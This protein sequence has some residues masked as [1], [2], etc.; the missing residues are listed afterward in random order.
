VKNE[1]LHR[2]KEE[3]ILCTINGREAKWMVTPYVGTVFQNKLLKDRRD[4]RTRM[5][6]YVTVGRP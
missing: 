1:V 3:S 6:T 4:K 2:A 5:K